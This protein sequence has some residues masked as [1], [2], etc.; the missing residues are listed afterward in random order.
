MCGNVTPHHTKQLT[1]T[2]MSHK[3]KN[4]A[5]LWLFSSIT[6]LLLLEFEGKKKCQ[7]KPLILISPMWKVLSNFKPGR[8]KLKDPIVRQYMPMSQFGELFER[9]DISNY[10][11]YAVQCDDEKIGDLELHEVVDVHR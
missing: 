4:A 5:P 7:I 9:D 8:G 2:I 10:A 6:L 1:F 11:C 3:S